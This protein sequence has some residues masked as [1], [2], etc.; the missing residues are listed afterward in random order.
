MDDRV[1]PAFEGGL[2]GVQGC[3]PAHGPAAATGAGRVEAHQRQVDALEGGGL[4]REVFRPGLDGD[5]ETWRNT[6][7]ACT[8]EVQR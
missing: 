4:V 1:E 5:I 7:D 6:G 3:F 8:E 2:E